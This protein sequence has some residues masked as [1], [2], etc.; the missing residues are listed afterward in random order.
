MVPYFSI[1]IPAHNE[2]KYLQKTI[3]SIKAQSLQDYET[4]IVTNGCT[5]KTEEIAKKNSSSKI[6]LLS[7]PKPNVSV[8][9]NAGALNA[10]GDILVFLD[11]DTQLSSTSLEKIKEKFT[12]QYAVATT[13]AKPDL[14]LLSYR[15]ALGFKNLYNSLKIYQG[16]SG[17]LICRKK[18]FHQVKGYNPEITLR[19]HR[20]LTL[21]LRQLGEYTYI[22]TAVIT[23]MRRYQEWGLLKA[24]TFWTRQWIKDKKGTL[25]ESSYETIR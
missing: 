4:I 24:L 13:K 14:P 7:L 10:Q 1:I 19:E 9:R 12:G 22:N 6:R 18:E 8:A 11:A 3:D 5:D 16:C 21:Q 15:L 17:A 20:K 25:K 2:E 23:S